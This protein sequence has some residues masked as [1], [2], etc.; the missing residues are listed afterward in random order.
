MNKLSNLF[1]QNGL[2][3]AIKAHHKNLHE[4]YNFP[5][6][7]GMKPL[8][9][10]AESLGLKSAEELKFQLKRLEYKDVTTLSN[11]DNKVTLHSKGKQITIY[12]FIEESENSLRIQ[13]EE[14]DAF[15]IVTVNEQLKHESLAISHT[16][17]G[18]VQFKWENAILNLSLDYNV[19]KAIFM[20]KGQAI[21]ISSNDLHC[22]THEY[23]II[24]EQSH[25]IEWQETPVEMI[26]TV[27]SRQN[28]R[29]YSTSHRTY[30]GAMDQ[31]IEDLKE[32]F[33]NGHIAS[34]EDWLDSIRTYTCEDYYKGNLNEDDIIEKALSFLKKMNV[35]QLSE[36]YKFI[37][38]DAE[39]QINTSIFL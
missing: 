22:A 10:L 34:Y 1:T 12:V 15:M 25:E 23:N 38:D 33:D 31:I 17:S 6:L 5:P 2:F 3:E 9:K 37:H 16:G 20:E 13:C 30:Q 28:E 36:V 7:K 35:E 11:N 24:D 26:Y 18:T 14:S 8:H 32:D 19:I 21:L 27:V 4:N 29:L 39:L